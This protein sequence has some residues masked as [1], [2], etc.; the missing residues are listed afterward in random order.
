MRLSSPNPSSPVRRQVRA[1]R[2]V[3]GA[4]ALLA[5]TWPVLPA[6]SA[7]DVVPTRSAQAQAGSPTTLTLAAD[8]AVVARGGP[9]SLVGRLTDSATGAGVVG[10]VVQ[11]ETLTAEGWV[12]V[13]G[14]TTDGAGAVAVAQTLGSSTTY[15][16]HHGTTGSPDES[17]SAA[18]TVTVAALTAEVSAPAV[19]VGRPVTVRGVLAAGGPRAFRVERRVGGSWQPLTTA[20]TAADGSYEVTVTPTT[21]GSW[22]LRVVRGPRADP[23]AAATPPPLDVFRLHTYSVRTR[24]AV[25]ADLAEFRAALAQTYADRRG[26]LRAHHRFRPAAPGQPGDLTVVLAQARYL[27]TYS[28]ICS[29][30]YSCQIGRSVIIN[31]TRWRT[32]SPAFPGTLDDYRRMVV[33]HETGHWL[34]RPHAYCPGPGHRAPVMQQQSKGMQGC[35]ANPWPLPREIAAVS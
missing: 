11:A 33:N 21:T 26:W 3:A 7:A 15:R 19:R 5:L 6:P 30:A 4:L 35:R 25:R 1:A 14:A 29:P 32:G 24:G 34:G 13:A 10:A 16:L 20:R 9:V 17:T 27:P 12:R 31:E 18:V 2:V 22:R 23:L 28:W 8:P